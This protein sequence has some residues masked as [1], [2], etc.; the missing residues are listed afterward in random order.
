MKEAT[1]DCTLWRTRC[2]RKL[3]DDDDDDDDDIQPK[4]L[5]SE[6]HFLLLFLCCIH[7]PMSHI[8]V[9]SLHSIK[10]DMRITKNNKFHT[11]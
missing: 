1:P 10:K 7:M 9:N 3:N 5:K 2:G 11:E 8:L 6:L 4:V